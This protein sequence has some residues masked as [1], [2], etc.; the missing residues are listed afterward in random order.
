MK[1]TSKWPTTGQNRGPKHSLTEIAA[2]LDVPLQHLVKALK[3]HSGP[4]KPLPDIPN[5]AGAR[6]AYYDKSAFII[7]FKSRTP[8]GS[9]TLPPVSNHA[10]A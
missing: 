3:D 9:A 4:G 2:A 6:R 1:L 10:P 5:T 8:N 7:W